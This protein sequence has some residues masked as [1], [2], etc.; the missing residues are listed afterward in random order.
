MYSLHNWLHQI[1]HH[2][3]VHHQSVHHT[4]SC[5]W[6]GRR[7]TRGCAGEFQLHRL[8][9]I[10]MV[11]WQALGVVSQYTSPT[12]T[13][14]LA[15]LLPAHFQP[16]PVDDGFSWTQ[17]PSSTWKSSLLCWSHQL[18]HGKSFELYGGTLQGP[19]TRSLSASNVQT[20]HVP[21]GQLQSQQ[22]CLW[23]HFAWQLLCT[24]HSRSWRGGSRKNLFQWQ[25]I[26][27][28]TPKYGWGK[29]TKVYVLNWAA[30]PT[31]TYGC[32]AS[33]T[34]ALQIPTQ[35]LRSYVLL[36]DVIF[37]YLGQPY[38]YIPIT[39]L[40]FLSKKMSQN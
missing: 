23:W 2:A 4:I 11:W 31:L 10:N 26:V 5:K 15:A 40:F 17:E 14:Q 29:E 13:R 22:Q 34:L 12:E 30:H 27:N 19:Q 18:A 24:N 25:W 28:P 32:Y 38:I 9:S 33:L 16:I 39:V 7:K 6:L 21:P 37:F 35:W 36:F 8:P 20:C 3:P 1:A